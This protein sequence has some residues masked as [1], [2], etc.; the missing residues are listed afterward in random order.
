MRDYILLLLCIV[1]ITCAAFAQPQPPDT[2][3][4]K[5]YGGEESDIGNSVVATPDGGFIVAGRYAG[6]QTW[7]LKFDSDGD[8]EWD[9]VIDWFEFNTSK[10]IINVESGGYAICG[11]IYDELSTDA[12]LIRLDSNGDTLWTKTYD[13]AGS[14]KSLIET[15]DSG[16]ILCGGRG[17]TLMFVKTDSLGNDQL[18]LHPYLETIEIGTDIKQ[19]SDSGYIVSG[20]R[21]TF[22]PWTDPW[23]GIAKF[24]S[25]GNLEW[26][27]NPMLGINSKFNGVLQDENGDYLAVGSVKV[28][29]SA[30]NDWQICLIR[31]DAE[32]NEISTELQGYG[33]FDEFA[34]GVVETQYGYLVSG[35][36]IIGTDSYYSIYYFNY[37]CELIWRHDWIEGCCNSADYLNDVEIITTGY[38]SDGSGNSDQLMLVKFGENLEVNQYTVQPVVSDFILHPPSPNPFNAETLISFDLP[39]SSPVELAVYDITGRQVAELEKGELSAGNH[40]IPF[41]GGN[42][43]SGVY[44][45]RLETGDFV[46]TR[47][48]VLIK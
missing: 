28:S 23:G 30:G 44:F 15:D 1:L 39:F 8:L 2:L 7:I 36:F 9:K 12:L 3:W 42:L 21:V 26:E 13:A 41:N 33:F 37:E 24:D 46:Q 48:C 16:F 38:G 18:I 27:Y 10:D 25:L 45:V 34:Y 20:Y 11:T 47:K 29:T 35:R 32:G 17:E 22:Y 6:I 43:V 5:Y 4:T 40:V 19:T 31:L 14:P